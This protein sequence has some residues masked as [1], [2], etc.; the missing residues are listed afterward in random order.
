[1]AHIFTDAENI[2]WQKTLPGKK[3]SAC[4][5]YVRDGHILMVKA[6]YKSRWTFP[7]GIVDENESPIA[8]AARESGEEIGFD[9][10]VENLE[11]ITVAYGTPRNGYPD[12]LKFIFRSRVNPEDAKIVLQE[13]EI[14]EYAW[15]A[16][17]EVAEYAGSFGAYPQVAA[18]LMGKMQLASYIET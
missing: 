11:F 8:A 6:N 3:I 13:S 1:M 12:H 5:A 10:G 18:M 7:S 17:D 16:L 4:V 14:E 15:I 2:A 9:P